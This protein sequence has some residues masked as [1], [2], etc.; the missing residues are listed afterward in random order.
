MGEAVE[1]RPFLHSMPNGLC[2]ARRILFSYGLFSVQRVQDIAHESA[3][4]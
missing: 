2:K 1:Q 4:S 3:H